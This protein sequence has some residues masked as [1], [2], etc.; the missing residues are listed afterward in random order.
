MIASFYAFI[1]GPS[2]AKR[3]GDQF[4]GPDAISDPAVYRAIPGGLDEHVEHLACAPFWP[5]WWLEFGVQ[6]LDRPNF[7]PF[8][9]NVFTIALPYIMPVCLAFW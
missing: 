7:P 3:Y 5:A 8:W 2:N 9:T 4:F 1:A 6:P